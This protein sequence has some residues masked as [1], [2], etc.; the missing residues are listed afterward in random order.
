MRR[1]ALLVVAGV[2]LGCAS[3][4]GG[5]GPPAPEMAADSAEYAP[6]LAAGDAAIAGRVYMRAEGGE[7]RYGTGNVI[8]LD[9]VTTY[10]R[11]FWRVRG[12]ALDALTARP[13]DTLFMRARQLANIA[14]EGRFIFEGLAPGWYYLHSKVTWERGGFW[15][16]Q[17]GMVRDSVLAQSGKT[18]SV[19]LTR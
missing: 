6:F 3:G 2:T 15:P 1:M 9:P 14:E 5:G 16:L 18:V 10:S 13:S 12:T 7:V 8:I 11:R 17:G 19:E 4:P